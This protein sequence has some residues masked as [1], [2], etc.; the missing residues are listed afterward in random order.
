M[1]NA[2]LERTM[3]QA[4][5]I[6]ALNRT[7]KIAEAVPNGTPVTLEWDSTGEV[8]KATKATAGLEFKVGQKDYIHIATGTPLESENT[9]AWFLEVTKND[10]D[11][12][13]VDS[14]VVNRDFIGETYKG[15]DPRNF[16]N[17][18]NEPLD[19]FKPQVGDIIKVTAEFFA[20]AKDPATVAGAKTVKLGAD[21]FS[22]VAD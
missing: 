6:D 12:W 5:N 22:A 17:R 11:V 19:T 13:L 9:D 10:G 8:F 7:A 16:V 15:A 20:T 4:R 2:V 14:P 3:V 21:G 18:A 1:A